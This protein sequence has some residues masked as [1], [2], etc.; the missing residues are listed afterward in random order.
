MQYPKTSPTL[1]GTFLDSY[2]FFNTMN[3]NYLLNKSN[4]VVVSHASI[5]LRT[6]G[7]CI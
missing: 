6:T 7:F 3:D 4:W 2:F 1:S 5:L